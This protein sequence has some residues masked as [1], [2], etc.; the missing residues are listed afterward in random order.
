MSLVGSLEDLGLADILQ[1]VNL[2]R[3]SGVLVL[4]CEQGEGRIVIREG[5]I[6]AAAVKGESDGFDS[7]L[8]RRGLARELDA[9]G[10]G[11]IEAARRNLIERAVA[12]MFEWRTGEFSFDVRDGLG[13]EDAASAL[14]TGLSPLYLTM[15]ATRRGDERRAGQAGGRGEDPLVFSG[16]AEDDARA[17]LVDA[18]LGRVDAQAFDTGADEGRERGSAGAQ[19]PRVACAQ[20][21]VVDPDLAALE[22]LKATLADLFDRVHIFQG[23]EGAIARIRQYLSRGELPAL[24]L[25]ERAPMDPLS[26][27]ESASELLRR[28]RTQAPR[29]PLLLLAEEGQPPPRASRFADAVLVRPVS[30]S[31][32]R[33]AGSRRVASAAAALRAR[34]AP[35]A[36]RSG[37]GARDGEGQA[38]GGEPADPAGE[39]EA[40]RG[41]PE[42]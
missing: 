22:W 21:V 12:R 13:P 18:I 7:L 6:H 30:G 10:L 29:M 5:L 24:L 23:A 39:T 2:A 1:I 35:F 41:N 31:L 36:R 25:S 9:E 4:R 34:L 42:A 38:R 8:Q 15:E 28:L 32:A 3:K 17:I 11:R 26:G 14:A 19:P 40:G 16:E 37:V 27:I 33:L 20:A